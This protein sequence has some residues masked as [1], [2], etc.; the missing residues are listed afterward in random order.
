MRATRSRLLFQ[1][2]SEVGYISP[3]KLESEHSKSFSVP[4]NCKPKPSGVSWESPRVENIPQFPGNRAQN[5]ENQD[6]RKALSATLSVLKWSGALFW[7]RSSRV[8]VQKKFAVSILLKTKTI[9]SDFRVPGQK[10]IPQDPGIRAE[11][12]QYYEARKAVSATLWV[13]N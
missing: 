7:Q 13:L 11:V 4:F 1:S 6:V 12:G 5:G 10:N 8:S 3:Q 2:Q 9:R